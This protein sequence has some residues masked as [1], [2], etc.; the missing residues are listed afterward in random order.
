MAAALT[1][2]APSG[3]A[4][5]KGRR[6]P[7]DRVIFGLLGFIVVLALWEAVTAAGLVKYAV[8]SSPTRIIRSALQDIS[9]GVLFGHIAISGIEYLLGFGI[10]VATG[11]PVGLAIGLFK[12]VNWLLDPWLSAIYATPTVALIP[13]IILILGIGLEAKVFIVW[14]EA[15]FVITVSATQG[16]K[17]A[18]AKYHDLAESFRASWWTRFRT[19]TLPAS[20]PFMLS[21]IRLGTGRALVGVVVAEILAANEGIGFYI[22]MSGQMLQSSKVYLGIIIL[23]IFG[24]T[25]GELVRLVEKRF[26]RW[27]PAIN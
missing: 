15:I 20:V 8:L 14:L 21:G 7:S 18:D 11:I 13:L 5:R 27:R 22:N 17:A 10:A 25:L 16:V 9:N 6:G 19:V 1:Q 2:P 12:K 4:A 23:G 26:D 3:E 24:I